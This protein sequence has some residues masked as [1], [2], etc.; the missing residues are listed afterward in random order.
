MCPCWNNRSPLQW[1]FQQPMMI[2]W[3]FK[4]LNTLLA[5]EDVVYNARICLHWKQLFLRSLTTQV[6]PSML[7]IKMMD[8]RIGGWVWVWDCLKSSLSALC[9]DRRCC[10]YVSIVARFV[11]I[12]ACRIWHS[13]PT[14]VVDDSNF[15]GRWISTC[16]SGFLEGVF[17]LFDKIMSTCVSE[18]MSQ[19]LLF[20]LECKVWDIICI[21]HREGSWTEIASVVL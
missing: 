3:S 16:V 17:Q 18:I 10:T 6:A 11:R 2:E 4:F 7:K 19:M 13:Y 1:I 20:S 5:F 21:F 9:V 8:C 14:S 12:H 15:C